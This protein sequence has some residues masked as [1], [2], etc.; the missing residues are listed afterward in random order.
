M[1]GLLGILFLV[2]LV[3]AVITILASKKENV[4]E[5]V[6]LAVGS[7]LWVIISIPLLIIGCVFLIIAICILFG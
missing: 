1:G 5:N 4:A 7:C 6:S 2:I 3:V